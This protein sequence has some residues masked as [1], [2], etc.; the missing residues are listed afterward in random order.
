M[1]EG[2]VPSTLYILC[3]FIRAKVCCIR[4][5]W[6]TSIDWKISI[7]NIFGWNPCNY[8]LCRLTGSLE[9]QQFNKLAVKLSENHVEQLFV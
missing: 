2:E 1:N 7:F 3:A 5:G 6:Q 4:S 8:F 9:R